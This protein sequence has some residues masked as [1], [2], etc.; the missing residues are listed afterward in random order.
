MGCAECS[1]C[2]GCALLLQQNAT[3]EERVGTQ[4]CVSSRENGRRAAQILASPGRPP[5][6]GR[7][8]PQTGP[9][10]RRA[11]GQTVH[12]P[13]ADVLNHC[14]LSFQANKAWASFHAA[15]GSATRSGARWTP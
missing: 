4:S 12:R 10:Y 2:G 15:S 11:S 5:G 8:S 14:K 7:P 6:G 13:I 1:S 9:P 3:R